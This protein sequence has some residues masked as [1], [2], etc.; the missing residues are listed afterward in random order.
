VEKHPAR[1]RW[2]RRT[3]E[4]VVDAAAEPGWRDALVQ[5][6]RG[7]RPR[8]IVDTTGVLLT[9]ALELVDRGGKVVLMGF[10]ASY[11]ATIRPL[12]LTNNG[13]SLIGAGDYNQN[14]Q[15]ALDIASGLPLES[16]ISHRLPLE[17]HAAAFGLLDGVPVPG[18]AGV[19][20][21]VFEIHA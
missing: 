21:V 5:G 13:I 14:L 1:L 19:M 4:H 2:A 3:F 18:E 11:A 15:L 20:K 6:N 12:Y 9:E 17:D 16:L 8:V 10:D 7:K